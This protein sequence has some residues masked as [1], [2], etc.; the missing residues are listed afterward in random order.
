MPHARVD[1]LEE[2]MA[3]KLSSE[4]YAYLS[5]SGLM[6]LEED[7]TPPT[8]PFGAEDSD[9]DKDKESIDK[10]ATQVESF[11][12]MVTAFSAFLD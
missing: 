9:T 2:S 12:A 8:S 7:S 5:N 11:G 10:V 3:A 4:Y 6:R 1:R